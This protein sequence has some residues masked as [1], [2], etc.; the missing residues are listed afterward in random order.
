MPSWSPPALAGPSTS[1]TEAEEPHRGVPQHFSTV[2]G[3]G[4]QALDKGEHQSVVD[5]LGRAQ[6]RPVRAPHAPIGSECLEQGVHERP[7]IPPWVRLRR[8]FHQ[9]GDLDEVSATRC[10]VEQAPKPRLTQSGGRDR[11]VRSG[12][13]GRADRMAPES[14]PSRSVGLRLLARRRTC[15][16]LRASCSS[17]AVSRKWSTPSSAACIVVPTTPRSRS[18]SNSER[19]VWLSTTATPL[20][21]PFPRARKSNRHR[22]S[23]S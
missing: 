21:R 19:L 13:S 23:V 8:A 6:K 2:V 20:N 3:I 14:V 18:R 10:Q 7:G 9:A 4:Y 22:L 15:P 12:R 16:A 1:S 5:P 11:G 17:V